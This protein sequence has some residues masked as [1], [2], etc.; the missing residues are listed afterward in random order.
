MPGRYYVEKTRTR[1]GRRYL[2]MTDEVYESLRTIARN[3]P[4][5]AKEPEDDGYSIYDHAADQLLKLVGKAPGKT[6]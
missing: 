3:R 5:L 1:S 4:D 6:Y 2:P